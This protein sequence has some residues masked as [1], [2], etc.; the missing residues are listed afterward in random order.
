MK[1][2]GE[3]EA[4]GPRVGVGDVCLDGL[5]S[6]SANCGHLVRERLEKGGVEA[7]VYERWLEGLAC[8][9]G[10]TN[11]GFSGAFTS[12]GRLLVSESFDNGRAKV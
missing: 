3:H 1:Q 9:L 10:E 4:G 8:A 5:D 12:G 6:R 2:R 7:R 11:D